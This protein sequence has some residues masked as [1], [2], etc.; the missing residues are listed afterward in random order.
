MIPDFDFN[1]GRKV[2][3]LR[4]TVREVWCHGG[5]HK[6]NLRSDGRIGEHRLFWDDGRAS[7]LCDS[8]LTTW[9]GS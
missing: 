6:A 2:P 5:G 7:K 1:I 4:S 3:P 9:R 8:S